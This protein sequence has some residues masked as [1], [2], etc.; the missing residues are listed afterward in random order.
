M[1]RHLTSRFPDPDPRIDRRCAEC[2]GVLWIGPQEEMLCSRCGR[3]TAWTVSVSD[4]TGGLQQAA[5][6][7]P[8]GPAN[9]V[10]RRRAGRGKA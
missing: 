7:P 9:G 2:G 1:G 8:A 4:L 3:V 10:N 5:V 6:C